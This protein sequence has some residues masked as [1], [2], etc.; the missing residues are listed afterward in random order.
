MQRNNDGTKLDDDNENRNEADNIDYDLS[1]R[2]AAPHD[3]WKPGGGMASFNIRLIVL[4]TT[5]VDSWGI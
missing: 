2:A 5:H 3:R 4:R 1:M